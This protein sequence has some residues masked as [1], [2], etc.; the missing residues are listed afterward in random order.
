MDAIA[1]PSIVKPWPKGSNPPLSDHV[2]AAPQPVADRPSREQGRFVNVI[3]GW[4][5]NAFR[6]GLNDGVHRS[7]RSTRTLGSSAGLRMCHR[8]AASLTRPDV[9]TSTAGA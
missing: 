4:G 2:R 5:S 1:K 3:A 6:P 8:G 9:R 7:L